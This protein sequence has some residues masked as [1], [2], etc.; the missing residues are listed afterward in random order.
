MKK[1]KSK[2]LIIGLVIFLFFTLFWFFSRKN[3]SVQNQSQ[4]ITPINNITTIPEI[5]QAKPQYN[6]VSVDPL[7]GQLNVPFN[8]KI[9]AVFE[10]AVYGDDVE[11]SSDP[12]FPFDKTVLNNILTITPRAPLASGTRYT[13]IFKYTRSA[14]PSRPYSFT[15]RG[16]IQNIPD[17]MPEG[18]REQEDAFQRE[19][20]PDVYLS[21]FTPYESPSFSLTSEFVEEESIFR[22]T[23]VQ[24]TQSAES[25]FRNWLSSLELSEEQ[26]SR[27]KITAQ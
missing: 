18:A 25:D 24:K 27:L 7:D 11:F 22:F 10:T 4:S 21:N 5:D 16:P 3:I 6:I 2:Y 13:Y 20:H 12:P 8:Q 23:M 19:N 1:I 26:I 15:T 14:V 17:T 9:T